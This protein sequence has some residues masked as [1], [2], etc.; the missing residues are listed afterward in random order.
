VEITDGVIL[1]D[2]PVG[3]TSHDVVNYIRRALK[4]RKV[5]H[6]GILDPNATGLM[7]MLLGKGTLLSSFL[8]NMSKRYVSRMVFGQETDTFDAEGKVVASADPGRI[9]RDEFL[10]LLGDFIG[11]IEQIIPPFSAAKRNGVALHKLARRGEKVNPR[12]KVVE[13]FDIRIIDFEWPEV[14]LDIKCQSG[15]YVRSI[16][17]QIGQTLGC[18]GYLK[19]L[20]RLEVGPF[21][22]SAA[23]TLDEISG[24]RDISYIIKPLREALPSSPLIDIKPQYYGAVLNGRPLYKKY[25]G[26]SN[27][28]GDGGVL[29]LLMGPD[30]KVLALANLNMHWRVMNKL[31]PSEIMGTY[32]RVIDEGR[33]RS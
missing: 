20:R 4:I 14:S 9:T 24:S 13:I 15:T 3:I 27:Y 5:G 29:S 2:K 26:G 33:L 12:H 1:V 23:A 32:V 7:V 30:G 18:G 17:H 19:S 6:T 25:I 31:G 28:E 8:T 16:A 21:Q 10:G 22:V 11:E